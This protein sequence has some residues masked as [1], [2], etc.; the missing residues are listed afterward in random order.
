MPGDP[1]ETDDGWFR[2]P[3]EIDEDAD[4]E[5]PGR[6]LPRNPATEPDYRHPLLLPLARALDALT[7]LEVRAEAAS[8]P[9]AEGLRARMSY[10]EASGWLAHAHVWIHPHDLA[11]RDR[12][13][14]GSYGAAFRAGRLEGEI[15]ATAGEGSFFESSPSDI[16]VDQALRLA[17]LWRRLAELSTWRPLA[18]TAAVQQTLEFLGSRGALADAEIDNWMATLSQEGGPLLIRAG[19]AARDWMNRPGVR[20]RGP[21]GVFFAACLWRGKSP[22][23][24]IALPFWSAPALRHDRRELHIGLEWMAD[25]LDCVAS[26]AKIGLEELERLRRAEEKSRLLRR[27]ARSHLDAAAA[28]VLR[29]PIV[30]ARNLA[31]DLDVSPQAALGLLRQPGIVR[32]ATG[33]SSW[34]AFTLA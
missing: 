11:L 33:R 21:E 15:P 34:R 31:A 22:S 8:P 24:P 25:F 14:T 28:A 30:T 12:G 2:P 16:V 17:R 10:R 7:R 27:T 29:A 3:W 4:L 6:P 19:R 5:P 32:E 18:D 20:S 23:Q 1:E 9:A 26:A 13:V